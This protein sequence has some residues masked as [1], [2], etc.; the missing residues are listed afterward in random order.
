M[1]RFISYYVKNTHINSSLRKRVVDYMK[2]EICEWYKWFP[3]AHTFF[4]RKVRF[5][6]R[7]GRKIA[8]TL[9][10]IC[11]FFFVH[12]KYFSTWNISDF[13][14]KYLYFYN[15]SHSVFFFL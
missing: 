8:L 11:M 14:R 6:M 15:K 10:N 13:S 5:E 1:Y 7:S 3:V 12:L 9:S 4:E 2:V